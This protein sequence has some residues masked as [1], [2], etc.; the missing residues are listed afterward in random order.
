MSSY[1]SDHVYTGLES[2]AHTFDRVMAPLAFASCLHSGVST[3]G[4]LWVVSSFGAVGCH[5]MAHNCAK[6]GMYDEF[7]FWHSMWHVVGVGLVLGCFFMYG[8]DG[9]CW[10]GSHWESWFHHK[11]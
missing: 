9:S 3:G 11:Q 10:E 4:M 7:V 1:L 5:V 8:D 2:W 6:K